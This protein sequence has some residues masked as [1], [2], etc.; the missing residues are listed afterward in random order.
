MAITWEVTITPVSVGA[1]VANILGVATDSEDP[2]NPIAVNVNRASLV[3]SP[4]QTAAL[5]LL[6]S[7][8]L[9]RV[10]TTTAIATWLS[11]KE[12]AAVTF[13]EAK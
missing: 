2:T 1:K 9:A 6:Y 13:L 10:A 11:G 4:A 12:A 7:R 3:D 5:N 8:Y